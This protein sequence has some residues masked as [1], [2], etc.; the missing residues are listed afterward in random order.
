MKDGRNNILPDTHEILTQRKSAILQKWYQR[1]LNSYPAETARFLREEQDP[2]AN[3]VGTTIYHGLE[4]LYEEILAK[5]DAG[6]VRD[7]LDSII[8]I[9]AVQ[10]F[11]PSQAVA[12]IFQ[13]KHVLKEELAGEIQEKGLS[14]EGLEARLEELALLAFDIYMQCREQLW[15]IKV[16]EIKNR[17]TRLL[18][19]ANLNINLP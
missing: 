11:S 2:F 3:P 14:L 13:L 16:E 8:R 9:R 10:D 18:Q 6:K 17:T 15:E 7:Y 5:M 1:I 12:F 4:G 19:R